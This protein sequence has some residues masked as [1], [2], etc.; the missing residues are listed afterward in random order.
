MDH[1][2][3]PE[4]VSYSYSHRLR[5]F[6]YGDPLEAVIRRLGNSLRTRRAVMVTW[7]PQDVESKDPPCITVI[8][9]LI[10]GEYLDV[11][12]YIRSNDMFKAWP[13]TCTPWL[14]SQTMSR[15]DLLN[16]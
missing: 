11:Y 13:Y 6:I 9:F 8:Q 12:T 15:R 1:K 10:H 3:P 2:P 7:G 4:G 16:A 14:T 5:G